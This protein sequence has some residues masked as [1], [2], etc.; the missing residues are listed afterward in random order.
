MVSLALLLCFSAQCVAHSKG[1]AY[2]R[3][4]H[5]V[6]GPES[7]FPAS[8][9]HVWSVGRFLL[10]SDG[11]KSFDWENSQLHI[12]VVNASYVKLL[13]N[14]TGKVMGRFLVSAYTLLALLHLFTLSC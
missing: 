10:N 14:A 2:N 7:F 6:V 1:K 9:P 3:R 4:S 12:N 8:D 13:V 5:Q 11:S